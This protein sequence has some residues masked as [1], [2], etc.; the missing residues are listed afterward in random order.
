M[1]LRLTVQKHAWQRQLAAGAACRP[2]LIP[3]VK[4]NGYGFG[5]KTLMPIAAQLSDHIAVGTVY[6]ASDVPTGRVA[7]VLTPHLGALPKDLPPTALLT[8]ATHQHVAA[9]AQ[10]G[11]SGGVVLKL[12]SS[13]RRYGVSPENLAS[14]SRA[15]GAAGFA[16]NSFGIHFPLSGTSADHLA[17]IEQWLPHLDSALPIAVSHLGP[18]AYAEL[19]QRHPDRLFNLRCGTALWHADRSTLQ[20]NADVVDG[21][22][23]LAGTPI[24]YHATLAPADGRIVLVAVG[25]SHG[26]QAL[27]DGRSPFH[28]NRTRL[29]MLEPA[30]M[31]TSMLFVATGQPCPQPGDLVDVQ[32]PLIL[33]NV[34]ELQWVD[35]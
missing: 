22:E 33:S 16:V 14:L 6:E 12:R 15:I 32:R 27:A 3:V 26:I 5:R 35:D 2:G 17:E 29:A 24:G 10:G 7:V 9:L 11:W 1:T 25:S 4:G 34:D 19:R 21:Y 23:V 31:H 20:L 18:D 13:M 30:H 28:F 8:V